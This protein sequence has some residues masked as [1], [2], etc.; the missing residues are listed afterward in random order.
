MNLS[1]GPP[2]SQVMSLS[3]LLRTGSRDCPNALR[4]KHIKQR[5][6]LALEHGHDTVFSLNHIE[7]W[8]NHSYHRHHPPARIRTRKYDIVFSLN[9][10]E[11]YSVT[12][13]TNRHPPARIREQG[14]HIV[15]SLN[16][17]ERYTTCHHCHHHHHLPQ[18]PNSGLRHTSFK[19][20]GAGKRCSECAPAHHLR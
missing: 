2:L 20:A 12:T 11:L 10:T 13:A 3:D 8:R 19:E 5:L 14:N 16:H 1:F 6:L 17:I 18:T 7:R 4:W 15:S 9:H